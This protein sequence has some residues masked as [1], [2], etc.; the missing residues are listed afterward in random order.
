MALDADDVATIGSLL[1]PLSA[2]TSQIADARTTLG[3]NM[4]SLETMR[5]VVERRRDRAIEDRASLVEVDPFEAFSDLAR[6]E[7]AL[8]AAV[9]VAAELPLP[10]LVERS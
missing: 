5:S 3:A 6:A 8:Q 4:Q 7:S 9:K 2:A 1:D 10:G